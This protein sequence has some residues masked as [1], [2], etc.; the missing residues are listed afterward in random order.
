MEGI[1]AL[2]C[3]MIYRSSQKC[4]PTRMYLEVQKIRDAD[5]CPV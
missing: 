2:H 1:A 4:L 3:D 5:A